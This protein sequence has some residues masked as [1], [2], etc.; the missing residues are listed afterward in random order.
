MRLLIDTQIV[1]WFLEGNKQLSTEI[2]SLI[3]NADNEIYASRVSLF[4]IAIKLKIGGRLNLKRGLEGLILDC[5]KEAIQV[6][7][8][9]DSHLLAYDQIPFFDDHRDPFDRLILATALA[10]KMAVI[11]ADEKFTRYRDVVGVIW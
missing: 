3:S 2:Y 9:T 1:I 11:S 7:P 10:E 4:E 6:M 5:Q 8:I